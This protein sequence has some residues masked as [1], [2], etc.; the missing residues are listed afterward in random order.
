MEETFKFHNWAMFA[1][2][3]ALFSS[4]FREEMASQLQDRFYS[5]LGITH[6]IKRPKFSLH[7]GLQPLKTIYKDGYGFALVYITTPVALST[8]VT[9]YWKPLNEIAA[10]NAPAIDN[11]NNDNIEF[12]WCTDFNNEDY[13]PYLKPRN[14]YSRNETN[15]KFE[16]EY[17]YTLYPDL[18]FTICCSEKI[19]EGEINEIEKIL[20]T[21][22]KNTYISELTNQDDIKESD[23]DNEIVGIFDF[24]DN[25]F[26]VSKQ[27]LFEAFQKIGQSEVAQK[28]ERVVIE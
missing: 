6:D 28:I 27:Q 4:T 20:S 21:T 17:D 22:I 5:T 24:Q 19:F 18:S 1:N 3:A 13:T 7:A 26:E 2:E 10:E 14:I 23:D 15:A 8:P 11:W 9:A 12:G 16:I 25:D